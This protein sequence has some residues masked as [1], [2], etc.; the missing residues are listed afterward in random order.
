MSKK[1][2]QQ[3]LSDQITKFTLGKITEQELRL[4]LASERDLTKSELLG[5]VM[6]RAKRQRNEHTLIAETAR[7]MK[8]AVTNA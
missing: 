6:A 5:Y 1:D 8:N 4:W 3:R 7:I 2:I